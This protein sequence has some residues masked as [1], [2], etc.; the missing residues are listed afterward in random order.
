MMEYN[1]YIADVAFDDEAD[2]FHG[3]V[4]NLRDVIAFQGKSVNELRRAFKE[5]I[6]DYLEFCRTRN[7]DPEKPYSGK[8]SVR[9]S[10]ELHRQIALKAKKERKS[11][12]VLVSE[13]LEA[14][15]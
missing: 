5:S 2:L 4:I 9:I 15:V 3:E 6:G 7:E 14:V 10:P 12:N 11:L 8:F 13:S 1:G